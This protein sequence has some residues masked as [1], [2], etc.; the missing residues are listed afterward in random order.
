MRIEQNINPFGP[1][2]LVIL[3]DW[4]E[5]Y[6]AMVPIQ[7]LEV[8]NVQVEVVSPGKKRGQLVLSCIHDF[9]RSQINGASDIVFVNTMGLSDGQPAL[10]Q[11][12]SE[13]PG[14]AVLITKDFDD[15]DPADYAGLFCP[16][17]RSPETL[18][19]N[20]T[21]LQWVRHFVQKDK[22]I[23]S[24][25]HGIQVLATAGALQGRTCTGHPCC[26][27]QAEMG[28][29]T[30]EP[31][32]LTSTVVD[33]NLITAAEWTATSGM[34]RELARAIGCQW[35]FPQIATAQSA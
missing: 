6:E 4:V 13:R 3:G 30:W 19:L 29:A 21:V 23:A 5:D 26:Q 12:V 34:I 1:K 2:V 33:G 9:D 7:A 35:V 15:V 17:G 25:C 14:H 27:P 11:A 22:P 32:D 24:I 10:Y 20:H 31:T 8:F 16:G 18:Q 28:G